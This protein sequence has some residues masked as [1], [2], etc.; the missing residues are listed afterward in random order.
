LLAF[1]GSL[2]VGSD[3]RLRSLPFY[4]SRRMDKRHYIVGKLLA[5]ATIV[6]L[7]TVV[8]AILLFLEFG[9]FTSSLDYWIENWR[10][11]LGVLAYGL[12]LCT[13]LSVL[14]VTTSAYLQ[15]MAPIAITW[16]SLFIMLGRL[17]MYLESAYD[18]RTWVLIDPWRDMRL[19]GRLIFGTFATEHDRQLAMAAA[20]L[21]TATCILC[22]VALV[23][24]VRAVDVVE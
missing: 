7:V 18:D 5:V 15:K 6:A 14:L 3:F 10:I 8:P 9:M 22:L 16:S 11:L 13:V 20:L 24:R 19:T 12:V 1:S 2:L 21:L 23:H 4:L 17:S